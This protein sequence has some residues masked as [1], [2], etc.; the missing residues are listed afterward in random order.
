MRFTF[1]MFKSSIVESIRLGRKSGF[2]F[3][4]LEM[5]SEL[6]VWVN[7]S[8]CVYSKKNFTRSWQGSI[9]LAHQK[10]DLNEANLSVIDQ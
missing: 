7:S 2:V 8:V 4:E 9:N 3:A 5:T 10:N 6:F 1:D